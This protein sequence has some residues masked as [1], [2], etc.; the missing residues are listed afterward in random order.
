MT[1]SAT[2][3]AKGHGR[4]L[5]LCF[6]QSETVKHILNLDPLHEYLASG[7]VLM[8]EDVARNDALD[9]IGGAAERAN[10]FNTSWPKE[11]CER[12]GE[13]N[14]HVDGRGIASNYGL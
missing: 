9:D 8:V 14:S 5:C 2:G 6:P 12:T 13:S 1:Q 3:F 7:L 4:L 11:R 10:T